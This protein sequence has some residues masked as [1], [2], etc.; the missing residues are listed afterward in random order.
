MKKAKK[1]DV[2]EEILLDLSRLSP[3]EVLTDYDYLEIVRD[4]EVRRLLGYIEAICVKYTT[5]DED[6]VDR[7]SVMECVKMILRDQILSSLSAMRSA[8][9]R[10][11]KRLLSALQQSEEQHGGEG[12]TAH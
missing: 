2:L 11:L 7:A 5:L 10:E 9:E 1:G 12:S 6:D 4:R 8:L 3:V